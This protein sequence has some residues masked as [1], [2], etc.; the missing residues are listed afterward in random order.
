MRSEKGKYCNTNNGDVLETFFLNSRSM[1]DAVVSRNECEKYCLSK[2]NCW[3]CSVSCNRTCEWK[4]ITNCIDQ[5]PWRGLIKG[6]IAQKT[7]K[8]L[9]YL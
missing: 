5:K 1:Q 8:T 9:K 7:G 2:E 3:G 6:D 4:A